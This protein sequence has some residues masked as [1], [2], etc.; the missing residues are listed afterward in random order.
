MNMRAVLFR[1]D[2]CAITIALTLLTSGSVRAQMNW[3]PDVDN[4][5]GSPFGENNVPSVV[6]DGEVWR[7][8]YAPQ[9]AL[10]LEYAESKDGVD[11]RPDPAEV[12][13]AVE[14]GAPWESCAKWAPS[15]IYDPEHPST[16]VDED[17]GEPYAYQ[18]WY[19]G[20]DC[21]PAE[22]VRAIGYVVSHDGSNWVRP[23][24]E[25]VLATGGPGDWDQSWV[26]LPNVLYD[27]GEDLY[28][29]WYAGG[30]GNGPN[31]IG[32]AT[33]RD[34][35]NWEKHPGPLE[36]RRPGEGSTI[37]CGVIHNGTHY[38]M[39]F[40]LWDGARWDIHYARS[41]DGVVWTRPQSSQVV[42]PFEGAWN[43]AGTCNP[44]VHFDGVS[45]RAW[46]TGDCRNVAG[47]S[48]LTGTAEFDAELPRPHFRIQPESDLVE[49]QPITFDASR[50]NS[51]VV[52]NPQPG[53]F[54]YEW[55]FGDGRT[56]DGETVQYAYDRPGDYRVRLT[57]S[58]GRESASIERLVPVRF[59]SEPVPGWTSMD[60][61]DIDGSGG[62]RP[63]GDCLRV[64]GAGGSISGRADRFHFLHQ[65]ITGNFRF[66]ATV[67]GWESELSDSRFGLMVRDGTGATERNAFLAIRTSS[68]GDGRLRFQS[69]LSEGD[70]THLLSNLGQVAST[71]PIHLRIARCGDEITAS[72]SHDGTALSEAGAVTLEGLG[73]DVLVGIA[74]SSRSAATVRDWCVATVCD[75]SIEPGCGQEP[76]FLRGDC[77]GD[78]TV[79]ISDA[80]CLLNWLFAGGEAPG[81]VA[82]TN[83]NGDDAAN[84]TDATYLL[85]HLFGEG[86]PPVQP[87]PECGPGALPTDTVLGC[88]NPPKCQ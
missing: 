65:E 19:N 66:T 54:S 10:D 18:M 69:R 58:D 41:L 9:P 15:V 22:A 6:Y 48:W 71:A 21:R 62:A 20:F 72:V 87:Y 78:G 38:E 85:T 33:S 26:H 45:Y 74:A 60:V 75:I 14:S 12:V 83:T 11:W 17:G 86:P 42:I 3:F 31:N 35:M 39:W 23:V 57:F 4:P 24:E 56:D 1:I 36:L 5:I 52:R 59:R 53:D 13:L 82:A 47:D 37:N 64:L 50:S 51:P 30:S 8:W 61:G 73:D 43:D 63:E 68:P 49:G 79:N 28:R 77:T 88:A 25:P 7:A 27:A 32:L 29:M 70:N 2:V 16:F 44:K 67:V 46:Y 40:S 80:T 76:R 55:D 34:G 81:C 84:I